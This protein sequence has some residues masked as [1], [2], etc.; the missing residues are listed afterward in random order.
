MKT[1][2]ANSA[3]RCVQSV[4]ALVRPQL[5]AAAA[6]TN[7]FDT[8][9]NHELEEYRYHTRFRNLEGKRRRT[10]FLSMFDEVFALADHLHDLPPISPSGPT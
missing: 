5:G 7:P 1:P 6:P 10:N 3:G 8:V 2:P 9:A 4:R